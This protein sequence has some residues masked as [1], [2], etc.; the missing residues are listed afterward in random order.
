MRFDVIDMGIGMS[1]A[2]VELA[3]EAFGQP[4]SPQSR[5]VS[6]T[7]L[8]L[9][10]SRALVDQMGGRISVES[11][12]GKGSRFTVQVPIEPPQLGV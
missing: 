10:I 3:F 7:G 11:E 6:G 2:Q 9:T 1:P 4:H 8:G 12:V 5:G